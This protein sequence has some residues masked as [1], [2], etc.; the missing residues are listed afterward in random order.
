[1]KRERFFAW[2]GLVIGGGLSITANLT[3]V[4]LPVMPGKWYRAADLQAWRALPV[5]EGR[6]SA[7][8]WAVAFPVLALL[9]VEL[10][11][12]SRQLPGWLRFGALGAAAAVAAASSYAHIVLVL[13]WNRQ[14]PIIAAFGPLAIDGVMILC[15]VILIGGV[16]A[17]RDKSEQDKAPVLSPAPV[18]S[19]A[20][21]LSSFPVP[22]P[23]PA[24]VLSPAPVQQDKPE[25]DKVSVPAPRTAR[26]KLDT[27]EAVRLIQ[28]TDW[29]DAEIGD[30]LG[31]SYKTIQR[32]RRVVR[33]IAS[34]TSAT[35]EEIAATL[36][37]T[38]GFVGTVRQAVRA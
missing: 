23:V 38:E 9:G 29:T 33:V 18:P 17:P 20:P 16:A 5:Q 28:S 31:T 22:A 10:V 19:P 26:T 2:G 4:V 13:L 7:Y 27:A 11:A 12:H 30:K 37:L 32:V 1:M 14:H 34:G 8:V 15:S 36:K 25:R 6:T 35:D 3:S 24:P 21:V